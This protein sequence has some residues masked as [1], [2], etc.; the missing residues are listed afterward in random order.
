MFGSLKLLKIY[1]FRIILRFFGLKG[2]DDEKGISELTLRTFSDSL[3]M[4]RTEL[5]LSLDSLK[6]LIATNL[7]LDENEFHYR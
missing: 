4:K 7:S 6:R 2:L 3:K 5:S 1:P